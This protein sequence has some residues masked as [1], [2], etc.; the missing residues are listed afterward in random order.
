MRREEGGGWEKAIASPS[1]SPYV[2]GM[3]LGTFGG[4]ISDWNLVPCKTAVWY[5][6]GF[7]I[8]RRIV[9][10]KRELN[11]LLLFVPETVVLRII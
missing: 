11:S 2:E 3:T 6:L 1:L 5:T 10:Q 9:W 4:Q 8:D 7:A